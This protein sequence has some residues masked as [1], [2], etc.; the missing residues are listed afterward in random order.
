MKNN[1]QHSVYRYLSDRSAGKLDT[2]LN[3]IITAY[4]LTS[5]S[6]IPMYGQIADVYGRHAA[7]QLSMSCM[8]VGSTLAAAAQ[9][10]GMLLLGRALQGISA[11][12]IYS[13]IKIVLADG[14][15][16]AENA[17]N[18]TI[19]ALVGGISYSV[20]PLIGGY[21]TSASWRYCFVLSIP[22]AICG[23]VI[24]FVLVRNDLKKGTVDFR[25]GFTNGLASIDFPGALLFILGV[26]LLILGITWGGSPYAWNSAAV[27]APLVIGVVLFAS[28]FGYQ[29]LGEP[30]RLVQRLLP[31]Q[32]PMIPWYLFQRKDIVLLCVVGF[33]TGA[34]M[35]SAFYFISIFWS[36]A[37]GL[38]AA[39][40]GIQLLY[41][42]PGIGGRFST[43]NSPCRSLC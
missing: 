32:V 19:F 23:Q 7:L 15:T 37:E 20:G 25:R 42:T 3:W 38:S 24:L 35:Y 26:G 21:L 12:G 40:T 43:A 1:N 30:G 14:V 17:K 10:W 39:Q 5:T 27:V 2:E 6:F 33:A 28:F 18:N 8:V 36:L 9:T 16:L 29:Y 41:Y 34:A 31:R 13:L 22:M 4:T 11:A